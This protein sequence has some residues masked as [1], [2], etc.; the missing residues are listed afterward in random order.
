MKKHILFLL[1]FLFTVLSSHSYAQRDVYMTSGGELIFSWG[2]L[3]Y[4]NNYMQANPES[5]ILATPTRFTCF[6]HFGEYT[7]LN[8]NNFIGFYT[9][10]GMRNVGFITDEV[11]P[12]PEVPGTTFD[13]KIVRRTYNLGVPLAMKVGSFKDNFHIYLGGEYEW[14]FHYKEKYWKGHSRDGEKV[15]TSKWWPN[16]ATSFIPSAFV[17]VQ[18]PKGVNLKLKYYLDNLLNHDYDRNPTS[19]TAVVSD[20]SKY[21]QSQVMYISLSIN[22]KSKE[23]VKKSKVDEEVV[24][25]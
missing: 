12:N 21:E 1:T 4:T 13:A 20:L 22:L 8:L 5:E 10:I 14:A 6:F 16:Q 3:Q 7:H 9:G 11:L 19:E 2:D 23:K 24:A 18:F 15:K 17:G 25:L